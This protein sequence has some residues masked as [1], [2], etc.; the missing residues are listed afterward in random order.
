MAGAAKIFAVAD[1]IQKDVD[2]ELATRGLG[3]KKLSLDAK[4]KAFTEIAAE[5]MAGTLGLTFAQL[6]PHITDFIGFGPSIYEHHHTMDVAK[7][8]SFLGLTGVELHSVDLGGASTPAALEIARRLCTQEE[9]LVLIAGAE[10]PR[11][12]DGGVRYYRE[13]SDALLDENT[14]LH[15]QANLISL[16]ALLADRLMFETGISVAD[17]EA[18]T[19]FYRGCAIDNP[20]AAMHAKHLK[21]GELQRYLAGV[22]ATAMVAVATDHGVAILVASETLLTRL[23]KQLGF[24]A[25]EKGLYIN[26]VGTNYGQKYLSHRSDFSSPA[27]LAGKRAFAR[28]GIHPGDIDYAWIYDCFTLMLVRQA[29]DYFGI[30]PRTA[31]KSLHAGF[32]EIAGKKIRVNAQGGILNTQ[33]AISLSAATGLIDIFDFA[34]KNPAAQHFF[35]G[36][37]GGIDC[38]NSAAILS[39]SPLPLQNLPGT[40]AHTPAAERSL[41]AEGESALL[42][43]A[44]IVRFNPGSD[45]PFVLGCFRRKNG[46]LFLARIAGSAGEMRSDTAGLIHDSTRVRF[47]YHDGKPLAFV[48]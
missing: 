31:A 8:A 27:G 16:Y 28:A 10:V 19:S 20:R 45:T 18:I 24:N 14:E 1:A 3:Y 44:A 46:S 26:A 6:R 36:G 43:A 9:R 37:N 22:Y 25:A 12:G 39:R 15:T 7:K 35:F 38:V 11:G 33:A 17:V 23:E 30:E 2:A 5:R 34:Q 42:Y 32:L 13:V 4:L 47:A 40:A 41:P 48:I 29:A 21:A